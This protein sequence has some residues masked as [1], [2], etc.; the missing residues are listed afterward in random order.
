MSA[1]EPSTPAAS[2]TGFSQNRRI[3]IASGVIVAIITIVVVF[4]FNSPPAAWEALNTNNAHVLS[5]LSDPVN[6]SI[7]YAGTEM[8]QVLRSADRGQTWNAPS[9]GLPSNA[10]ISA[11]LATPDDAQM[12]AGTSAGIY[13]STDAGKIWK[14][15]TSGIPTDDGIDALAFGA[16]DSSVIIAGT[17][18]HGIY[19]SH[20]HGAH[21]S[22]SST[23][24]PDRADVYGLLTS[25]DNATWYTA[26]I[27]AGVAISHDQGAHWAASNTG[28]PAGI[29]AFALAFTA[30]SGHAFN[31]LVVGTS[32]GPFISSDH[33]QTWQP[34]NQ[35]LGHTRVISLAVYSSAPN[36]VFAGTDEGVFNASDG[37]QSWRQLALGITAHEHIGALAVS[38][39]TGQPV[40]LLAAGDRTY[41]YPG[42]TNSLGTSLLRIVIIGSLV[43]GLVL[44]GMRQN[45]VLRDM[46][47]VL[48][49]PTKP[50][51]PTVT[52]RGST[53]HIRG[54]PPPRAPTAP[55]ADQKPEAEN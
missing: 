20:D 28:L 31:Q 14:A 9:T 39:P 48:P 4:I 38:Q 32:A 52:L 44:L 25:A 23:G 36:Q 6:P 1:P 45:R 17:E 5:L 30:T 13:L 40:M 43:G 33:G 29:D 55:T 51:P 18:H 34:S 37:G 42:Q 15:S 2:L 16:S 24:L 22:A 50:K 53:G 12:Y 54:G 47:P 49:M 35:G 21:W 7:M 26:L 10:A 41:R 11:L 8:G 3:V 46:T 19:L 27:G